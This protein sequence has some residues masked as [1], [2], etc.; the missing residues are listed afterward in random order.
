M[1]RNGRM[2]AAFRASAA[3]LALLPMFLAVGAFASST[4]TP[5]VGVL[6]DSALAAAADMLTVRL[7][8][9]G[10]V[11]VLERQE[12]GRILKEHELGLAGVTRAD[13]LR[14]GSLL[15]ADGLVFL[16]LAEVQDGAKEVAVRLVAV[17]P[18]VL[19]LSMHYPTNDVFMRLDDWAKS[20]A[21]I[22]ERS[23]PKIAVSRSEA[24]P[25]S[26]MRIRSELG[27]AYAAR[28]EDG[29][30]H[31]MFL[32]LMHEPRVFVLE[33]E[34]LKRLDEEK[35]WAGD[36]PGFW[37]GGRLVDGVIKYDLVTT[38]SV[39]VSVNLR[40][41]NE[42]SGAGTKV[43][44]ET[45]DVDRLSELADRV[46]TRLDLGGVT[47]NKASKWDPVTEGREFFRQLTD[48]FTT[49]HLHVRPERLRWHRETVRR[50]EVLDTAW[51]LGYRASDIAVA[52]VHTYIVLAEIRYAL[53]YHQGPSSIKIVADQSVNYAD[54][55]EYAQRNI[56]MFDVLEQYV[57][58]SAT[59]SVGHGG[60]NAD[61]LM[62][63][64]LS[65]GV[66]FLGH[67]RCSP[68]LL[69]Q[70]EEIAEIRS[71]CSNTALALRR[72]GTFRDDWHLI[73]VRLYLPTEDILEQYRAFMMV[74]RTNW[75][76]VANGHHFGIR[77]D[78]LLEG[79][80]ATSGFESLSDEEKA[81]RVGLWN[82]F[83]K[84]VEESAIPENRLW[85]GIL[86]VRQAK[87]KDEW[88]SALRS[89]REMVWEYR[90]LMAKGRLDWDFVDVSLN[91]H[92]RFETSLP[93]SLRE[94]GVHKATPE[95]VEWSVKMLSYFAASEI[96]S[97]YDFKERCLRALFTV[98]GACGQYNE[99]QARTVVDAFRAW[100]NRS[101]K[102][103]GTLA[104]YDNAV[105]TRFPGLV[106]TGV[107]PE[108]D[109]IVVRRRLQTPTECRS[110]VYSFTWADGNWWF[111]HHPSYDRSTLRHPVRIVG[112]N[113]VTEKF[114]G[115][116][117]PDEI[118]RI[119]HSS[120]NEASLKDGPSL[121]YPYLAM[122]ESFVV[123]VASAA[124]PNGM[125][126]AYLEQRDTLARISVADRRGGSWKSSDLTFA[127]VCP[128]A[129]GDSIYAVYVVQAKTGRGWNIVGL[130]RIDLPS[131]KVA[132]L[133]DGATTE[134][135]PSFWGIRNPTAIQLRVSSSN[136]LYVADGGQRLRAYNPTDGTWRSID[137]NEWKKTPPYPG[138]K[139]DPTSR[140]SFR[141][142]GFECGPASERYRRRIVLELPD[143]AGRKSVPLRF[144]DPQTTFTTE[145]MFP[146]SGR[147]FQYQVIDYGAV[148]VGN[149]LLFSEDGV[150]LP[151]LHTGKEGFWK[152][153]YTDIGDYLKTVKGKEG[154]ERQ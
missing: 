87:T 150:F 1:M 128:V 34:N 108:P 152:I 30:N 127:P 76:P 8:A 6:G 139:D 73:S 145:E 58:R 98:S 138:M 107:E 115:I 118:R 85:S 116:A 131:F 33:R 154:G 137:R 63:L 39:S 56:E 79:S 21:A 52:R 27:S 25:V 109:G 121:M 36:A 16:K 67:A 20:S 149:T 13:S 46:V 17:D 75:T 55:M 106:T 62:S 104:K 51:T 2:F 96:V 7:S 97:D 68:T 3:G 72:R 91:H 142:V 44:R 37:T 122:T 19:V 83:M 102:R 45:G 144:C 50:R 124:G 15:K 48:S 132:L 129:I 41:R 18:G 140:S 54:I 119:F 49:P 130:V 143:G 24:I 65:T 22:L 29:F 147:D 123:I 126:D 60:D 70:R 38:N 4:N 120:G 69:K 80:P 90:E 100:E 89:M 32:R 78:I 12:I 133:K 113:P 153:L 151:A 99:D 31:A 103:K 84:E 105:V 81:R 10:N 74:P 61:H 110:Y 66:S 88:A 47:T 9:L 148:L 35:S 135:D 71:R 11:E 64:A 141:V 111:L 93:A 92:N 26:M 59:N 23:L 112:F 82:V 94:H 28:L 101:S 40:D 114:Q 125:L 53:P 95:E 5:R 146:T 14:V 136:E 86:R 57:Y 43:V 117:V 77:R 42:T 134:K